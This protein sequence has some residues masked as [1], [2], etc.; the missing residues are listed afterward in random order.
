MT[1]SPHCFLAGPLV[2]SFASKAGIEIADPAYFVTEHRVAQLKEAREADAER[3]ILDHGSEEIQ[4]RCTVGAVAL[5]VHGHLAAA[6]STGGMCNKWEG[7]YL[8]ALMQGN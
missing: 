3:P 2:S 8:Y 6:T 4:D 1:D 5:D 7:K